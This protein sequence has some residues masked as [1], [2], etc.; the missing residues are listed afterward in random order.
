MA[1]QMDDLPVHQDMAQG[2]VDYVAM[3]V[4]QGMNTAVLRE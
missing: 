3:D 2:T 4:F 1:E